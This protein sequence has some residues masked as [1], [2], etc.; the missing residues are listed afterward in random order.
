MSNKLVSVIMPLYNY[1]KFVEKAVRSLQN[2]TYKNLEIIVVDDGSTDKSGEIVDKLAKEDDRIKV[3]HQENG[4]IGKAIKTG[5]SKA[6]G[7]YIAFLDSDDW[8]EPNAYE[9]LLA[10][11]LSTN[12]DIVEFGTNSYDPLGNLHG[13]EWPEETCIEG[14]DNIIFHYFYKDKKP[15]E[16]TKFIKKELFDN[17]ELLNYSACVDELIAAQLISECKKM[18]KVNRGYYNVV[19]YKDSVSNAI[20]SGRKQQ[21]VMNAYSDFMPIIVKKNATVAYLFAIDVCKKYAV[22]YYKHVKGIGHQSNDL[23]DPKSTIKEC[24]ELTFPYVKEK[25]KNIFVS[26]SDMLGIHLFHIS[27]R[28]FVFAYSFLNRKFYIE[29]MMEIN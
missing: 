17:V 9:E 14:N 28:L 3:T 12:A 24:F 15:H 27:P 8:M 23:Q 2:Q 26:K 4:G 5:L 29:E 7:D 1:E 11:A 21:E 6:T 18:V 16:S 20:I 25:P 13:R 22:M 10:V 19:R